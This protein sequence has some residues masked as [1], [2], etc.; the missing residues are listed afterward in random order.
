MLDNLCEELMVEILTRLPPK[1]LLRFRSVSKSIRACIDSPG[2]I[3]KHTCRSPQR[4]VLIHVLYNKYLQENGDALFCTLHAQ[5][6]LP[7]PLCGGYI[8]ITPLQYPRRK[9]SLIGFCNGIFLLFGYENGVISLW[10]P[11]IKRLLTLPACP[12]RL[13]YGLGYGLGFDPMTDDNK[14]VSIPA[15]GNTRILESSFVY[16]TKTGA[17]H[18]IDSRMPLYSRVLSR[19]CYL[20]GVLHWVVGCC[21][22]DSEDIQFHYIM[23]FDLST[24]VFGIID[25]PKPSWLTQQ[26]QIIQGSLAVLSGNDSDVDTW[27]WVRNRRDAYAD[28]SWSLV[29]KSETIKAEKGVRKALELTNNGDLLLDAFWEGFRVYSPKTGALLTLMEFNHTSALLDMDTYVE[30]LELL[31]MGT[32]C[33]EP[34][35]LFLQATS[36]LK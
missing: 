13:I 30:T 2:F 32:A 26:L 1:S 25:L 7:L 5:D 8:G 27:I 33:Q 4:L 36:S 24:H 18:P 15:N 10:N 9:A 22:P 31:H 11:S 17:W 20:N 34:N 29:L 6:Q 14:V 21:F 3:R 19:A 28:S 12:R 16:A 35:P 23:T